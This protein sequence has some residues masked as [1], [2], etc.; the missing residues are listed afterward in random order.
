[1]APIEFPIDF[2]PEG[3]DYTSVRFKP[4][5]L[6][7][8]S[9]FSDWPSAQPATWIIAPHSEHAKH[10]PQHTEIADDGFPA[11]SS[12]P[13]I[14][15]SS[16]D[17][18]F[19]HPVKRKPLPVQC[20]ETGCNMRTFSDRA[21]LL[22]HLREVHKISN[23]YKV[24]GTYPCQ[25]AECPRSTKP[26]SRLWNLQNHMKIHGRWNEGQLEISAMPPVE[27]TKRQK[28]EG[29]IR[30]DDVRYI[31]LDSLD[32]KGPP[33]SLQSRLESLVKQR[34]ELDEKIRALENAQR[35]VEDMDC[36]KKGYNG[37]FES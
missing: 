20:I 5:A 2:E 21:C 17:D 7:G 31:S 29:D 19:Q 35:I 32:P 36:C 11:S 28:S 13:T 16:S 3:I 30:L 10:S 12:T 22:R 37:I 33:Q 24:P 4:A 6:L 27:R 25:I 1:M 26:F 9:L 34:G 14:E 15:S 8:E 18:S 23:R